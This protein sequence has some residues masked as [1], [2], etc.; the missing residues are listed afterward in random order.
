MTDNRPDNG[1]GRYDPNRI[2]IFAWVA[3]GLALMFAAEPLLVPYLGASMA[4]GSTYI[5]VRN[6]YPLARTLAWTITTAAI[7]VSSVIGD[8]WVWSLLTYA[9]VLLHGGFYLASRL[10]SAWYHGSG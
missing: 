2:L 6:G 7:F 8:G 3:I 5:F 10:R 9:A 4:I 1:F